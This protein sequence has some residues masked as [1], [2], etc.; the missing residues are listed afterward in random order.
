MTAPDYAKTALYVA[1]TV[2][3]MCLGG[4]AIILAHAF[5][6]SLGQVNATLHEI[7]RPCAGNGAKVEA[8]GTLAD[9]AKTLGTIRGTAGQVEIAAVHEN[10]QL[11][12]LDA[13]E[14]QIYADIHATMLNTQELTASLTDTSEMASGDL[15]TLNSTIAA[16]QEPLARSGAAIAHVD[17]TLG[18]LD[19]LIE[20]PDITKLLQSSADTSAQ[21]DGTATDVR[22]VAD[23][24]SNSFLHPPPKHWWN[25]A[26]K[27]WSIAWQGAMLAK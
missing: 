6:F 15:R 25:Y 17:A 14:G 2:L 22:L 5:A 18:H 10:A 7:N 24:V 8:C 16:A 12:R 26:G 9:V 11:G 19:A 3:A 21:V 1:L 4:A 27:V 20:D 23:K 13:Q